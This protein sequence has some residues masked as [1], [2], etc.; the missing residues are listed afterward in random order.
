MKNQIYPCIWFNG[1]AR[2]AAEFYCSALQQSKITDDTQLVVNFEIDGQKIMLLNGGPMHSPNPS[3]SFFVYFNS[4]EDLDKS[5]NSL[6]D[7][8]TIMM[9]LDKYDW[10]ERYGWLKDKF[11]L[12]WQLFLGKAPDHNQKFATCLM[13]TQDHAGKAEQAIHHYTSIFRESSI[14]GIL[15]YTVGENDVEGYVKHAEFHLNEELFMAMDS[16][17]SHDFSFNEGISMVVECDTQIEI[18]YYWNKLTE[19]GSEGQCGWLKDKFGV[20]WQII[21]SILSELMSN[22]EKSERVIQAFLKMKKFDIEILR[23]A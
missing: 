6:S 9:P 12:S 22:P 16:T 20:S 1:K 18:D 23:N 11:G 3:I 17:L 5:W 21:P 8:G 4:T 19:G 15:K 14:G 10:S 7:K 13:F 2:E